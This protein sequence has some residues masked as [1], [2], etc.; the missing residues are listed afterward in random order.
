VNRH[1]PTRVGVDG[2]PVSGPRTGVGRYTGELLAAAAGSGDGEIRFT[3]VLFHRPNGSSDLGDLLQAGVLLRRPP[4]AVCKLF[5]VATR[6]RLPVPFELVAPNQD[7]MLFPNYRR[8]RTV[9]KPTMTV[10]YDLGYLTLPDSVHPGFI[11]RLRRIAPQ[12]IRRS[13]VIGVVS[14]TL[15]GEVKAAYPEASGRVAVIT[16]GVS[17]A[18][19]RSAAPDWRSRLGAL[20]LRPGYVLHVGTLEPRKN[21]VKLVEAHGR[22]PDRLGRRH[23]LVLVGPR[24]WS[25][26]PILEAV[27]QAAHRVR[28]LPFVE[29]ADLRV[30]YQ[31]AALLT[32]PTRYEGFGLPVLEAMALGVPVACSD[33]PVLHEVGQEA[34]AYFDH[35]DPDS[36]AGVV[37][38]LLDDPD[39][40][41][42]HRELGWQRA[43]AYSW[44]A[45]GRK[46]VDVLLE[47]GGRG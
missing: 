33:I 39:L 15:A 8:Y 36:I 12:A 5:H 27:E 32:F 4:R 11:R 47:L 1:S 24:G 44:E 30:L 7:I 38:G 35:G 41:R 21:L 34:V 13:E 40:R 20:G 3:T 23:P 18:L 28:H 43:S 42:R 9:G 31:G 6:L 16:P 45:S 19:P 22:L 2:Y 14:E 25:D 17:A 29:D 26:G 37:A 46:L 10:V